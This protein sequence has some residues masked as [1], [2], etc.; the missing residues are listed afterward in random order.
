MR[1]QTWG[2]THQVYFS[3]ANVQPYK[4][5]LN[6]EFMQL[7]FCSNLYKKEWPEQKLHF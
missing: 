3:M 6:A 2:M 7:T 1:K 4:Q 5:T